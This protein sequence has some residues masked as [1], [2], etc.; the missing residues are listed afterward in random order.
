VTPSI[1]ASSRGA[2]NGSGRT[3]G[4]AEVAIDDTVVIDGDV[5][6]D[7]RVAID[8]TVTT[9]DVFVIGCAVPIA[10]GVCGSRGMN[11]SAVTRGF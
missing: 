9:E 11:S 3:I 1:G 4:G 2:V 8:D 10:C 7:E 5:A 6:V